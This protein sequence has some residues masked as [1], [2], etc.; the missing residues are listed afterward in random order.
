MTA[1]NSSNSFTLR[2]GSPFGPPL[3]GAL[4]RVPANRVRQHTLAR[5]HEHGF[6]DLETAHF[7]VL[8]YPGP[9]GLRPSELAARLEISK[10]ALNYLLGQLE[11]R[12]YVTRTSDPQDMR[13]K[14]IA[15]TARGTSAIRVIR[16]AVGEMEASWAQ[17]LGPKRFAQLQ[18]LLLDL[19]RPTSAS[20]DAAPA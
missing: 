19:N 9:Q 1:A 18:N 8:S 4:L 11:T 10:Q 13:S 3:I 20:G 14:R 12:G 5:L 7:G 16:E 15:L 17:Q 6:T 2:D